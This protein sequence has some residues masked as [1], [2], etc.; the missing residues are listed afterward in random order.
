M[1]PIS[2]AL[3]FC[4]YFCHQ[5]QLI[6]AAELVSSS[7]ELL[8]KVVNECFHKGYSKCIKQSVLSYLDTQVPEAS[9]R[10]LNEVDSNDPIGS[11]VDESALDE[12]IAARVRRYL[13][14]HQFVIEA[15]Q[16]MKDAAIVYKPAQ[17][18]TDFDVVYKTSE[19]TEQ[20][21]EMT[22]RQEQD[23]AL[24][25]LVMMMKMKMK[26]IMPMMMMMIGMKATKALILSKLSII[27]VVVFMIMQM[28][29]KKGMMPMNM[30]A[31]PMP[32][33]SAESATPPSS[34]G[35]ASMTTSS[36]DPAANWEANSGGPYSRVWDSH[37]SAYSAYKPTYSTTY[38][39][40]SSG[41]GV[42]A[43]YQSSS[44]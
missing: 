9:S 21:R 20:A 15:P 32:P 38:S 29:S 22:G 43:T 13:M 4:V 8:Y 30:M 34:Y 12:Q 23:K 36:Y 39:S 41:I 31:M 33:T 14:S 16:Y 2:L 37:S 7:N 11:G 1:K 5:Y 24:M 6:G 44:Y 40:G 10:H 17:D 19:Q 25:P 27:I 42:A 35:V 28:L 26:M 3:V 18:P